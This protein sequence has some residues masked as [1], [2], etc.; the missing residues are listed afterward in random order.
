M[1]CNWGVDTGVDLVV[2]MASRDA[3]EEDIILRIIMP[4]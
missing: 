1:K 3:T 2:D 4:R